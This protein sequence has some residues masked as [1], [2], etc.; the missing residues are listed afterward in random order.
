M[1][2]PTEIFSRLNRVWPRCSRFD[3]HLIFRDNLLMGYQ[4]G[5]IMDVINAEQV[6]A[7]QV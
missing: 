6:S 2:A 1:I 7:I 5:V 3:T 4:G